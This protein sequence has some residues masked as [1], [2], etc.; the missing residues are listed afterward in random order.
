MKNRNRTS[1]YKGLATVINHF[2]RFDKNGNEILKI[3]LKFHD[4]F[5][6]HKLKSKGHNLIE[7]GTV[8]GNGTNHVEIK[9]KY[10]SGDI[11]YVE[12]DSQFTNNG[13]QD[14]IFV[15]SHLVSNIKDV[16]EV[17]MNAGDWM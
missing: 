8:Y 16:D 1:H 12:L 6:S 4:E 10:K 13:Y 7:Q 11:I 17:D 2:S 14:Y 5:Y 15:K 9:K 3:N